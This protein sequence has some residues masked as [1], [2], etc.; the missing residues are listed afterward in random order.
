[1]PP[2]E[3]EQLLLRTFPD[4]KID[5]VDLTGTQNHYQVSIVSERFRGLPRMKQH[6]LV[7]DALAD[8]LKG[9]IHALSLKTAAE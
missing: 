3:L 2:R 8:A 7:Y 4:A 5:I 9:P 6:R 1:M